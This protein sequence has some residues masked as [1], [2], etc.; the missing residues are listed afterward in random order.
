MAKLNIL[1]RSF[2]DNINERKNG[3]KVDNKGINPE[4]LKLDTTVTPLQKKSAISYA[5]VNV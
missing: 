4:D 3:F 5:K 1:P 2:S